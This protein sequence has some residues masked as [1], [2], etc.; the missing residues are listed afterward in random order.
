MDSYLP[1]ELLYTIFVQLEPTRLKR[2]V[3]VC[4]RWRTVVLSNQRLLV[5]WISS[6]TEYYSYNLFPICDPLTLITQ[7]RVLGRST[8][9]MKLLLILHPNCKMLKN[10]H[11]TLVA[12]KSA[13]G[14]APNKFK[15]N[16]L[17]KFEIPV[18]NQT[19]RI[20][21]DYAGFLG[22]YSRCRALNSMCS[23][24]N[25]SFLKRDLNLTSD[26][27]YCELFCNLPYTFEGLPECPLNCR[28]SNKFKVA[29]RKF[30]NV[31][32]SAYVGNMLTKS[33]DFV[34]MGECLRGDLRS[35]HDITSLHFLQ[36]NWIFVNLAPFDHEWIKMYLDDIYLYPYAIPTA[37]TMYIL[38][39]DRYLES[40]IKEHEH[41]KAG[42][43]AY[44]DALLSAGFQELVDRFTKLGV[45]HQ[46][47]DNSISFNWLRLAINKD[48]DFQTDSDLFNITKAVLQLGLV[49]L[50]VWL[51]EI[52]K[53]KPKYLIDNWHTL[54]NFSAISKFVRLIDYKESENHQIGLLV[55]YTNEFY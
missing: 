3:L 6:E 24:R 31:S 19:L 13:I 10:Y 44:F 55:K 50:A 51:V 26:D 29:I 46:E 22:D 43:G 20:L 16:I 9:L 39:D 54:S 34:L 48:C 42:L 8:D 2:V 27:Y 1:N 38:N 11:L 23:N 12:I 15:V 47:A 30:H 53:V 35:F 45:K 25:Q 18:R 14:C 4:K 32:P 36:S 33:F 7:Y 49:E 52:E 40:F 28:Y 37:I 17:E 21:A 41:I 5:S